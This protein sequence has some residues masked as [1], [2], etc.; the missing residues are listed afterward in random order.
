MVS[1]GIV[2]LGGE[3]WAKSDIIPIKK[4]YYYSFH[5]TAL[6]YVW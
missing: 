5:Y 4:K 2:T 1:V 3:I 6:S